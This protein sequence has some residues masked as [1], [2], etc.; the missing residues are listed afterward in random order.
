[1]ATNYISQTFKE[2]IALQ[3]TLLQDKLFLKTVD[4]ISKLLKKTFKNRK[5]VL[6]AGNG[7]SAADA[8]HFAG[9]FM[10]HYKKDRKPLPAIALNTD[11]SS[12]TAIGNDYSFD[13][14]FNRQ[15]EAL[16][17][18]GDIFIA[19]STSGNSGNILNA[20]TK[21]K[22]LGMITICFL[23]KDGGK[24]KALADYAL[25]IPS[26]N[27]PRIQEMHTLLLHIISEETESDY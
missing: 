14:I 24:A 18:K 13:Y 1:V 21:A 23:G 17:N 8:Q 5:K 22:E 26:H 4:D 12:L 15:V 7:G 19:F 6:I 3:Q 9:E 16:G 2:S 10:G 11:T 20:L 27:T 25:I